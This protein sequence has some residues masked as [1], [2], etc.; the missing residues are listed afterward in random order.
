MLDV[1]R[2]DLVAVDNHVEDAAAA[3]RE[4]GFEPELA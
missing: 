1:L 4:R 3:R 2:E